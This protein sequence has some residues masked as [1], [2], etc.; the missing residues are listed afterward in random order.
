MQTAGIRTTVEQHSELSM[1]LPV[2]PILP[3]RL[4]AALV[5]SKCFVGGILL[6]TGR[7]QYR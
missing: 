7:G 6:G 3:H 2:L 1:F 5:L 4:A